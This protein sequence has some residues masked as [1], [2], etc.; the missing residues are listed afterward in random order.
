MV[1]SALAVLFVLA[2]SSP[3]AAEAILV[4]APSA[5]CLQQ[6]AGSGLV[7]TGGKIDVVKLYALAVQKFGASGLGQA[8]G[9]LQRFGVTTGDPREWARLFVMVCQ[10]ESGC[11]IAP[12]NTDGSLQKFASTPAG[13]RSYGPLQFNIGEYGLRSWDEVNS[14][15]CT[16][17]AFIRVAQQGKLFAYFGSMQRSNEVLQHA[18]WFNKT[19]T[20]HA[21][22]TPL[23]YDPEAAS[24]NY[25]AVAPYLANP[26]GG[27]AAAPGTGAAVSGTR[28]YAVTTPAS[29]SPYASASPI[30][31]Q[32]AR[33]ATIATPA[34]SGG[35]S[36]PQYASPQYASPYS[37]VTSSASA[38]QL[39]Q[40]ILPP[41]SPSTQAL[42][43]SAPSIG[44]I[45]VRPAQTN[46]SG[47]LSISWTSLNM[48]TTPPC[49][50]TA[51][52]TVIA[53]GREG[54]KTVAASALPRG[55]VRFDFTCTTQNGTLFTTSATT[56]ID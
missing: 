25:Q 50:I 33:P 9:S 45:I 41:S 29:G 12:K 14:P 56:I 42:V 31:A 43:P 13:E 6:D 35:F 38:Q 20:P 23:A 7:G 27:N 21:D 15:S 36:S 28:P 30:P 1:R 19:V 40:A 11:R 44:Q 51:Q 32:T 2:V 34:S 54:A 22:G 49:R 37:S 52:G 47:T 5:S 3:H 39:Q 10:Q 26:Y 24:K 16:L 53:E 46:V 17:D 18:A 55:T 8:G 48:R 4:P